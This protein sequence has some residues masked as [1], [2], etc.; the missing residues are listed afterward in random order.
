MDPPG[1]ALLIAV[2]DGGDA[3]RDQRDDAVAAAQVVLRQAQSGQDP[4]LAGHSYPDATSVLAAFRPPS[5]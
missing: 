4:Q 5:A 2:L 3:I 1:T